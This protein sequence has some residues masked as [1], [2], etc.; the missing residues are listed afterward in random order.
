MEGIKTPH[1]YIAEVMEKGK[2]KT[3]TQFLRL[4]QKLNR[5]AKEDK[6]ED[7]EFFRRVEDK[8]LI[9]SMVEKMVTKH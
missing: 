8:L 4:V 7:A 9:R 2:V 3:Y 5:I 1:Q 6:S